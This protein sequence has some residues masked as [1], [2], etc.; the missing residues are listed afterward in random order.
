VAGGAI[1]TIFDMGPGTVVAR[2]PAVLDTTAYAIVDGDVQ[3]R[4]LALLGD[5]QSDGGGDL[6]RV[7]PG[8]RTLVDNSHR[9]RRPVI[10]PD[11][12]TLIIEGRDTVT[13]TTDLYR[14]RLAP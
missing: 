7:T 6:W 5:I 14:L 8:T 11:G 12:S 4:F 9:W 10:S 2:D 3:D 13:G 1:D